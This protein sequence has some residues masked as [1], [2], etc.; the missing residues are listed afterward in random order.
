M[1][2]RPHDDHRGAQPVSAVDVMLCA[3]AALVAGGAVV[4]LFL[5]GWFMVDALRGKL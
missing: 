1:A 5:I 4:G 2:R 3:V